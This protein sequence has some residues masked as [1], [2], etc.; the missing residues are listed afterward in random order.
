M[1]LGPGTLYGALARLEEQG[2]IEGAAPPRAGGVPT[3]SRRRARACCSSSCTTIASVAETGLAAC[4]RAGRWRERAGAATRAR[5]VGSAACAAGALSPSL[6]RPLR[7]RGGRAARGRPA[8]RGRAALA[9]SRRRR[10]AR[11]AARRVALAGAGARRARARCRCAGCSH[12]GSRC[13]CWHRLPEGDRGTALAKPQRITRS[14]CVAHDVILAG[15]VL[16]A[17]A[18]AVGGLPLLWLAVTRRRWRPR[19]ATGLGSGAARSRW[20][21]FAR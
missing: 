6:A 13:R 15:A 11:A 4:A 18:I 8:A 19:P 3:G 1:H 21:L 2:L 7:G 10:R 9:A 17:G 16:G 12:A 5:T 20:S 14:C